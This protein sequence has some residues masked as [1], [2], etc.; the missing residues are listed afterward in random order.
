MNER[1]AELTKSIIAKTSTNLPYVKKNPPTK[2]TLYFNWKIL[3]TLILQFMK[4]L[5]SYE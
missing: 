4:N 2:I 3:S 5:N 1:L